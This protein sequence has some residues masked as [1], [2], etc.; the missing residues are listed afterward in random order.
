[1]KKLFISI[2][3]GSSTLPMLHAQDNYVSKVCQ[4]AQKSQS[5]TKNKSNMEKKDSILKPFVA[6][7][8]FWIREPKQ[9]TVTDSLITIVSEPHTDLWQ[10][11]YYGFSNDNAPVLQ[12]KTSDKFFSFTVK[13][14]FNSS[15][16]FDQCGIAIYLDSDNWMKASIEYENEEYQRLGSVVTNNGYSD[17]AT[18]DIS[19]SIKEM[20]YRLSRRESDYYIETSTDGVNFHQMRAFHLVKGDG[21]ISF[22]LYAASPVDHSFTAT[23]TEMKVEKCK[24]KPGLQKKPDSIKLQNDTNFL[25][26]NYESKKFKRG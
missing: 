7:N 10:R 1:M 22:G 2:L 12:M 25:Q 6:E 15:A 11:T 23:F 18:H 26:I 9:Y 3:L 21:E 13:T 16:L 4:N 14:S 5:A 24:W 20:W 8:L 17:W 19:S